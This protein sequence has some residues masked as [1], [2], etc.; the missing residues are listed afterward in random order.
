VVIGSN[1]LVPNGTFVVELVAFL[2]VLA[3]LARYVLPVLNKQ[4]EERQRTIRQALDDAE[5][6]RRRAEEAEAEYRRTIE[7]ARQEARGTVDEAAKL[8]EQLRAELRQRGDQ[9]Y[10][11]I[12]SRAQSDIDSSARRAAEELRQQ[13]ADMVITVVEK[14][15]GEGLDTQAHRSLID[16]TIAEVEA[17]ASPTPAGRPSPGAS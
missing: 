15:V 6:A 7:T 14:V 5:T 4:M 2:L 9:E 8:G 1:F 11:R 13:L 17:E 10:E 12:I 3:A 16:R